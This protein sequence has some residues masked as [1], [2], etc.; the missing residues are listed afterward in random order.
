MVPNA[1]NPHTHARALARPICDVE[2]PGGSR[3]QD[4]K[5]QI[6]ARVPAID[7]SQPFH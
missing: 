5:A 7:I 4:M 1:A 2:G 3:N 6:A